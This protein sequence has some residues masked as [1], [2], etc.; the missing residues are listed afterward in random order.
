MAADE[1][2]ARINAELPPAVSTLNGHAQDFDNDASQLT[3]SFDVDARFVNLAGVVQGGI[4]TVL[5]DAAMGIAV[6][7]ARDSMQNV[8]T[9]NLNVSFLKP[10]PPGRLY[11]KGRIV[12][13]GGRIVFTEADVRTPDGTITARATATSLLPD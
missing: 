4:V 13:Q 10:T 9:L 8:P 5:L 6:A 12:R 11:A 2:L 7:A 3:F 1:V